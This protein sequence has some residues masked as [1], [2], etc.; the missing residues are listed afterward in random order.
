VNIFDLVRLMDPRVT[1]QNSK[2]HLAG[3][4]GRDDPF[5][6]Y[7]EGR[8]DDWQNWQTRKNFEREHVLSLIQLPERGRW[9][10]AGVYASSGCEWQ[11][12]RTLH[13]YQLGTL[14]SCAEFAGRLIVSFERPGRQSYLNGETCANHMTVHEIRAEPVHLE[15]F[16]GFKKVDLEF[17]DL[18]VIVRQNTTSW[19]T[20]L[21]NV[22]GVS[23]RGVE[24]F[25]YEA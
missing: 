24:R 19:R 11:E 23:A 8:F 20:V 10:Y 4:N 22:A 15:E 21:S 1:A 6:V 3:W 2:V 16:P 7:L 14:T 5:R 13:R 9:L 17:P 25:V 12:E 18:E